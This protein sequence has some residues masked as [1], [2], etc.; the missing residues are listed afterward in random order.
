MKKLLL[1]IST[2]LLSITL[3]ACK[4]KEEEKIISSIEGATE[5]N[6]IDYESLT[7]NDNFAE[8]TYDTLVSCVGNEKINAIVFMG[9]PSCDKCQKVIKDIQDA[10]I[11]TEQT[12]YYFNVNKAI[13]TDED[14][15]RIVELLT[16]ILKEDDEDSSKLALYTPQV[17]LIIDGELVQGHIGYTENYDYS[18]LMDINSIKKEISK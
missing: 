17:F 10:A 5:A 8:I 4:T 6:M 14:Y 3:F 9:Y 15:D 12:V 1:I 11:A 18:K 2:L 13:D 16:P 7:T